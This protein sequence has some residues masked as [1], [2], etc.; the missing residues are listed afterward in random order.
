MSIFSSVKFF[1]SIF[2]NGIRFFF[3]WNFD[4]FRFRNVIARNS[5]PVKGNWWEN[6]TYLSVDG[7]E[8]LAISGLTEIWEVCSVQPARAQRYEIHFLG[9][10][11]LLWTEIEK[12][13]IHI[14]EGFQKSYYWIQSINSLGGNPKTGSRMIEIQGNLLV[15]GKTDKRNWLSVSFPSL[16]D[17]L[18]KFQKYFHSIGVDYAHN[19][20]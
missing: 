18:R 11:T 17:N 19:D 15:S 2:F 14:I 4:F 9:Q 13:R 16:L 12:Q 6:S 3:Q 10:I 20:H 5:S 7:I 1:L 8:S